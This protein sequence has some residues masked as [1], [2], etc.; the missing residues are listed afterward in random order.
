[1]DPSGAGRAEWRRPG[2]APGG[3]TELEREAQAAALPGGRIRGAS[4]VARAL[5]EKP[6]RAGLLPV[7]LGLVIYVLLLRW[8]YIHVVSPIFSYLGMGYQAMSVVTEAVYTAVLILLSFSMAAGLDRPT[9]IVQWFLFLLVVVPNSFVPF[10]ILGPQDAGKLRGFQLCVFA[11]YAIME[12]TY[13]LPRIRLPAIRIS[14]RFFWGGLVAFNLALEGF[15]VLRLHGS[16]HLVGL[17]EVYGQRALFRDVSQGSLPGYV[18]NCIG[19]VTDPFFMA[20]GLTS[21]RY[22]YFVFGALGQILVYAIGA[23]KTYVFFIV[24]LPVMWALLRTSP[25]SIG[26]KLLWSGAAV[27]VISTLAYAFRMTRL[28]WAITAFLLV[29]VFCNAGLITAEFI[30]F[31]RHN[32]YTYFS[33]VRGFSHLTEYPFSGAVI[34]LVG[35]FW[36]GNASS[37][38]NGHLWADGFAGYGYVGI[39]FVSALAALIVWLIDSVVAGKDTKFAALVLSI[40]GMTLVNTSVFT[41]LLTHGVALTFVLLYLWPGEAGVASGSKGKHEAVTQGGSAEAAEAS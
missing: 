16:M 40:A 29:R 10:Y 4:P 17:T 39:L 30:T 5:L 32:P 21:K 20:Y 15:L 38:S 27:F 6:L 19:Y 12:A 25:N 28:M 26:R 1:M 2:A 36:S 24:F 14:P 3:R 34:D 23:W 31:F 9:R 7:A 33:H 13:R 22:R 8:N 37:V 18:A 35:Q 41:W 11:G